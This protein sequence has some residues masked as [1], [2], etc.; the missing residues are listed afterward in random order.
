[1]ILG[2]YGYTVSFALPDIIDSI[3]DIITPLLL[4]TYN[5][6]LLRATSA[7]SHARQLTVTIMM[8]NI[9][10]LITI[11]PMTIMDIHDLVKVK[12]LSAVARTSINMLFFSNSIFNSLVYLVRGTILRR[13]YLDRCRRREVMVVED[14][15]GSLVSDD[16]DDGNEV[17]QPFIDAEDSSIY[18]TCNSS[19][20]E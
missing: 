13:F 15:E 1:M 18:V 20:T 3:F 14:E 11:L 6:L 10:A 5:F 12:V 4:V 9:I 16:D 19:I 2:F 17:S 8:V 7:T